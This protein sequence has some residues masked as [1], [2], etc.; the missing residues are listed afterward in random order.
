MKSRWTIYVLIIVA[1]AVWGIIAAKVISKLPK[2]DM[3]QGR[4]STPVRGAIVGPD[5]LIMNYPDP[6]FKDMPQSPTLEIYDTPVDTKEPI[7]APAHI[8]L[9]G[10]IRG[11]RNIFY[12]LE[13]SGR[14]NMMTTGDTI[15]GFRLLSTYPDSVILA[16]RGQRFTIKSD[17]Q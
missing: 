11:G 10:V 16:K 1:L 12:I 15:D 2:S 7:L 13:S 3:Q 5:T 8:R 14:A 9:K 4:V 17:T 6:F